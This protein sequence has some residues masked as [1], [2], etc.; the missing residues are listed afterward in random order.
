[1]RKGLKVKFYSKR[2]SKFKKWA[3]TK[4]VQD[5]GGWVLS[6]LF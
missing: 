3:K 5:H 4:D 2:I 1:M 6:E